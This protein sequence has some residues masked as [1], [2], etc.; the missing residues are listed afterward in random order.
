MYIEQTHSTSTLLRERYSDALPHLY[1]IRTDF[2]TAG[3]GQAG[4]S[5]ESEAGKNLLYSS[6]LRYD[7]LPADE[8]WRLSM[9]VALTWWE[10]LA[11]LLPSHL[12]EGLKIKWPND[13][14][15]LD[16]KLVGILIENSLQGKLIDHT[17]AGVGV[18]LNQTQWL[19]PAPNPISL[20]QITGKDYNA[21]VMLEEWFLSM[22]SWEK[23]STEE[24]RQAYMSHIYRGEGLYPYVEREVSVVPTAIADHNG[25]GIFLAE[26]VDIS[27]QGELLLRKESGEIQTYHFKQ[28]RFVL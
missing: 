12:Q 22:K 14:Y 11:S 10:I 18:N 15:Y 5:W 26:L 24:I 1:T 28:I 16:S 4:N 17:M 21:E 3:R 9:L 2:Q 6:L 23:C 25:D 20:K 8:Q 7:A 27:K 13:I 19:S